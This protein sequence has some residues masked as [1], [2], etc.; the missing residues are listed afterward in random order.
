MI[1][2]ARI[3]QSKIAPLESLRGIA[4]LT[5]V[6][7]HSSIDCFLTTNDFVRNGDLM[8]NF[9][10]VLSGY[11][12]A[13]NYTETISN[14]ADVLAFQKRRFWRLYP[15]HFFTLLV[16]IGIDCLKYVF[17]R[18]AHVSA[19]NAGFE[20][21]NFIGFVNNIFLT[22]GLLLD[23]LT[24]NYPSWSISTEF[25]TYLTF[26]ILMLTGRLRFL[27]C[28]V[29]ALGTFVTLAFT[30]TAFVG[31][32]FSTC[33]YS[34]F[35]GVIGLAVSRRIPLRTPQFVLVVLTLAAVLFVCV[36]SHSPVRNLI[37]ILFLL[38]VLGFATSQ[39]DGWLNRLLSAA[40]F[41]YIG[42]ISYSIYL[43]HA[44]VW[45]ATNQMLRYVFRA[46]TFL[47]DAGLAKIRLSPAWA[48]V[49]VLGG[50]G[51]TIL[52]SHCT[53]Q[54]IEDRFRRGLKNQKISRHWAHSAA[55]RI[56][57]ENQDGLSHE[58]ASM[59]R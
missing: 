48:I 18:Y 31:S 54:W 8:V 24:F 19:N 30:H 28:S 59:R 44:S 53:F 6:L 40:P 32:H 46:P 5:V 12:I 55:L 36:L 21:D 27:L 45:W 37:P 39:R 47:T 15:L 58:T 35:L 49:S 33:L 10:F 43:V 16:F 29:V 2:S 7:Y 41:T 25:Y 17:E 1:T 26:A 4:A 3:V 42:T 38:V 9:F 50:L 11:V 22:H 56:E 14:F 23:K 34:F 57:L 51:I 52:L 20:T 13:L